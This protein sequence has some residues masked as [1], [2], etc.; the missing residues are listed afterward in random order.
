MLKVIKAA[1][2]KHKMNIQSTY[3]CAH[4]VP[5][6]ADPEEMTQLIVEKHIPTVAKDCFKIYYEF[7]L[8]LKIYDDL[9]KKHMKMDLNVKN[10]DVFCEEG[11]YNVDQSRRMLAAGH[12]QGNDI[13]WIFYINYIL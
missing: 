8:K 10:I 1:Q 9:F 7:Y 11:V 2:E 6:G 4:A 5:I 13:C 12:E 3:L